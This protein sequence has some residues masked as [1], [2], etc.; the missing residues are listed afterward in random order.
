LFGV[1]SHAIGLLFAFAACSKLLNWNAFLKG[2]AG[3]GLFPRNWLV[4]AA[5]ALVGTESA[6]AAGHLIGVLLNYV[7]PL[8]LTLLIAFFAVASWIIRR[9]DERPCLCFGTNEHDK[10][11]IRSLLR[12]GMLILGESMLLFAIVDVSGS[13]PEVT[14]STET[15]LAA[16]VGLTLSGWCLALPE[17]QFVLESLR[18]IRK[19]M[20]R[21]E[22]NRRHA[23]INLTN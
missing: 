7:A 19:R 10:I 4:P 21:V 3:Y 14:R 17:F 2:L 16:A 22:S 5:I 1:L 15:L 18:R 8:A 20:R 11:G 6:I 23:T 12:I 13:S 9:G